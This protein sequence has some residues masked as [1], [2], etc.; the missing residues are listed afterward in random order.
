MGYS[1]DT[2]VINLLYT[3]TYTYTYTYIYTYIY[4][5]REYRMKIM[6]RTSL[7]YYSTLSACEP[8]SCLKSE[9][10]DINY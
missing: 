7:F 5:Y 10:W 2:G 6:I 4:I 9:V 8:L 1:G 3:Y